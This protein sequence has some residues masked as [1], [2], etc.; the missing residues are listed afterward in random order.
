MCSET[1]SPELLLSGKASLISHPFLF[2][3]ISR[4]EG[5]KSCNCMFVFLIQLFSYLTVFFILL[6]SLTSC[7]N[8]IL[9]NRRK[10][11]LKNSERVDCHI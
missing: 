6:F 1:T 8:V 7:F 4:I 3:Y 5:N 10:S 2:I 9:Q 11:F